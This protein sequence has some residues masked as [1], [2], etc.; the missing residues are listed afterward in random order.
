MDMFIHAEATGNQ[1]GLNDNDI[2]AVIR[3]GSDFT[4]NYYEIRI[5]LKKTALG[6][7]HGRCDLAFRQ[8]SRPVPEQADTAKG[9]SE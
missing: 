2:S 6:G 9:R 7:C 4:A 3:L 8:Q 1:G 5:P